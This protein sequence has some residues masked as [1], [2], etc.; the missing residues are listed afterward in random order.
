MNKRLI[1]LMAAVLALLSAGGQVSFTGYHTY[2]PIPV[3]PDKKE[4]GLDMIYVVYD[5]DSVDMTFTTTSGEPA[6]WLSFDASNWSYPDT[7]GRMITL[8]QVK[9]N[10]G[11]TI[12]DG[13]DPYYCWVVNYADYMLELNDM[14]IEDSSCDL[15]NIRVDGIG[16]KILYSSV[17]GKS[18]V[19]DRKIE[20][21]YDTQVREDDSDWTTK[22]VVETFE[23]L[24]DG[25]KLQQPLCDTQFWLS[26]DQFLKKWNQE[27]LLEG[28]D[29]QTNAVACGFVAYLVDK[30]GNE[31]K[32]DGELKG[33]DAPA[34]IV[35]TGFP[36]Q[37]AIYS[38]WEIASD[39][40]FENVFLQYN[41]NE[42][43]YT[44]NDAGTYYARYMVANRDGDCEAYGDPITINLSASSLGLD[45]KGKLF[46]NVFTPGS[47]T[48]DNDYWFVPC[49]SIVEFHCWIFNRWGNLV[50]EYTDP[51]GRW[52]GK[53]NGSYVDTGVYYFVVTAVGSDGEKYEGKGDITVLH[54]KGSR[55]TS[56]G[57]GGF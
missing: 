26:G 39:S 50:Y 43:D 15:L 49:K 35:F 8:E 4:T 3:T 27:K 45:G 19:L 2:A 47:S 52:D 28:P 31:K 24:D 11:Y 25:I 18:H 9:P 14:F 51:N 12:Y 6:L 33:G 13:T 30:N 46:P 23:S 20:L 21:S 16:H 1:S 10:M 32:L 55:G 40:E 41:Q 44:F 7:L 29:Y 5:T 34:H 17:T 56:N 54:S 48:G 53:H 36:S 22:P 57:T 38:K 42:V 37:E